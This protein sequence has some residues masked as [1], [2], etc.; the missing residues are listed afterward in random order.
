MNPSSKV[1]RFIPITPSQLFFMR[2]CFVHISNIEKK[3]HKDVDAQ[4]KVKGRT[5]Q[6]IFPFPFSAS[7]W[8]KRNI[9]FLL[10]IRLSFMMLESLIFIVFEKIGH[11]RRKLI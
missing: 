10:R 3:S 5:I 11:Q 9:K 6:K 1:L 2:A 7:R 8:T 4:K